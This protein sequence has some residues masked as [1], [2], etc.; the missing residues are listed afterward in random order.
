MVLTWELINPKN[1]DFLCHPNAIYPGG[2]KWCILVDPSDVSWWIQAFWTQIC[3]S[4]NFSDQ[5]F[6]IQNLFWT[7]ICFTQINLDQN[8][9]R[10]NYFQ[11]NISLTIFRSA[12]SSRNRSSEK[13]EGKKFQIAITW[14]LLL[15]L[16]PSGGSRW[17]I[18]TD[19]CDGSWWI[20]VID[21]GGSMWW[22]LVKVG[23]SLSDRRS[24]VVIK[25]AIDNRCF[26]EL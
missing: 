2:F 7:K 3:G 14:S 10:R 5:H 9:F 12:S 1:F 16:P 19:P 25:T 13:Q 17:W 4:P 11:P 22:I 6:L 26:T 24:M 20:H 23:N 8:L 21:P 15:L 18:L